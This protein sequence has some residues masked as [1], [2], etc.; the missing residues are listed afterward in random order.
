MGNGISAVAE[1]F[2]D[3]PQQQEA[4]TLGMWTFLATEILFFGGLFMSYIV[5]RYAYPHAFAEASQHTIVL[6]G[7]VNTAILL[8]SSL[9]MALAVHAAQ[10]GRNTALFRYLLATIFFA[11]CFL[12]VKGFEYSDDLEEHLWPGRHFRPEL[13]AQAQIFW[14]LY[15]AM[16]GLHA[17]HV[18]VGV[19][20]LS[21]I[22]RMAWG[23]KFSA[24]YYNPVD[25]SA[26]YW[27]FVD[28]VWIW[29]YPLLYLINRH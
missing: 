26:L 16:T 8:T 24:H 27:H 28:I 9:T 20:V 12:V 25:I 3:M 13:P 23:Q 14:F 10:E 11:C 2:D 15:W 7:T 6:Y 21:V 18:T 5:Y 4:S 17:L 29:L 22:A 19:G 1:Q